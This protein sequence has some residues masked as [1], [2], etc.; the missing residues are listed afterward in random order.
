MELTQVSLQK[1]ALVSG[2]ASPVSPK[3]I[4]SG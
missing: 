4:L 2:N 3:R 1:Q